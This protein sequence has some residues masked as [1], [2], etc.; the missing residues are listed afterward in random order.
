MTQIEWISRISYG[1]ERNQ[2]MGNLS[3][4]NYRR[5][6]YQKMNSPIGAERQ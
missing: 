5:I 1:S 2:K 6:H 3:S 4:D